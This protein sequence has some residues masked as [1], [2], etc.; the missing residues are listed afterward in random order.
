MRT[1]SVHVMWDSV[2]GENLL[3]DLRAFVG[4]Q[5]LHSGIPM[6]ERPFVSPGQKGYGC[7]GEEAP[8]HPLRSFPVTFT[9]DSQCS[10]RKVLDL[11]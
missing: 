4:C 2:H 10:V 9:G 6:A 5:G 8:T 1:V 7:R 3:F 11:C